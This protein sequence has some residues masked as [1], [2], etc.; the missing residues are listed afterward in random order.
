MNKNTKSMT[1]E[2][3]SMNSSDLES[4][5]NAI[6]TNGGGMLATRLRILVRWVAISEPLHW[7]VVE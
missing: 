4:A 2:L 6:E 1:T 7:G 5:A 3:I